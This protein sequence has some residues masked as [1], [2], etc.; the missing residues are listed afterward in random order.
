MKTTDKEIRKVLAK[1]EKS[2]TIIAKERD[3]I[4]EIY[5]ELESCLESFDE[6]IEGLEQGKQE[7]ESSLDTLSQFV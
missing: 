2:K 6:G 3:K 7:I 4:R 5:G 1:I